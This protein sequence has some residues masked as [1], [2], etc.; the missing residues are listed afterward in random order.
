MNKQF[1]HNIQSVTLYIK[2]VGIAV[3]RGLI[4]SIELDFE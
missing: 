1:L 4:E 3:H 2:T